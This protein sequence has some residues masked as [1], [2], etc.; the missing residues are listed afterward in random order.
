MNRF[1]SI[2]GA[3]LC[4]SVLLSTIPT[5]AIA[6]P[7]SGE[8]FDYIVT[9]SP[10]GVLHFMVLKNGDVYLRGSAAP[11]TPWI[12]SALM[13]LGNFWGSL[14]QRNDMIEYRIVGGVQHFVLLSNGDVYM[15][16]SQYYFSG[17]P[18][19]I[20]NYWGNLI[21]TDKSTWGTIKSLIKR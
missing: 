10:S 17:D 15:R 13:F 11:G 21:S 19:Y 3:I 20:G 7:P 14:P 2:S 12:P 4:L 1:I 8:F 16:E 18:F 6:Q 9:A 5:K